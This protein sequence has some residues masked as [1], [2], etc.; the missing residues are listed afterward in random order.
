VPGFIAQMKGWLTKK[1][2]KFATV[3]VDKSS[4]FPYVQLQQNSSG[5]ETVR[6]KR[7]FESYAERFAVKVNR[8]HADNLENG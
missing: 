6:A 5:E 2:C 4:R 1:R 3:L 8:Y 7:T